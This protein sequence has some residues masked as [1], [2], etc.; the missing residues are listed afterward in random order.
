MSHKPDASSPSAENATEYTR[1][2]CPSSV[3]THSPL[4]VSHS[5]TVLSHEPDASS[6]SA[7]NA[8]EYTPRVHV[9]LEHL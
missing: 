6:P 3:R 4:A 5:R 1:L 7:E 2:A 9:P 8:T